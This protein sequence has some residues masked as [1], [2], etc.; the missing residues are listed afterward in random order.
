MKKLLLGLCLFS[1]F[2][3]AQ[4]IVITGMRTDP[5]LA[6]VSSKT[7]AEVQTLLAKKNFALN[8]GWLSVSDRIINEDSAFQFVRPKQLMQLDLPS[9][10]LKISGLY[11]PEAQAGDMDGLTGSDLAFAKKLTQQGIVLTYSLKGCKSLPIENKL[12][13]AC[14]SVEHA[15]KDPH[16]KDLQQ[17]TGMVLISFEVALLKNGKTKTSF[18]SCDDMSV[19]ERSQATLDSL[20][21][22]GLIDDTELIPLANDFNIKGS[23]TE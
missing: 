5:N 13:V 1:Q 7:G 10:Q 8:S 16:Q 12:F 11:K 6:V 18:E 20:K 9:G 3:F 22:N 17:L 21:S 4:E 23:I 15:M 2:A 14:S 19:H